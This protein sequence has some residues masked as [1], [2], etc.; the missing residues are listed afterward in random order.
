MQPNS[1]PAAADSAS[2]LH[3]IK[4]ETLLSGLKYHAIRW[5]LKK[6]K[7]F[8]ISGMIHV[9]LKALTPFSL[10]F[11]RNPQHSDQ[12]L[13]ALWNRARAGIVVHYIRSM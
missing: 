2:V 1:H 10:C 12:Q 11:S 13:W 4:A 7:P 9:C 8:I 3:S 5:H 6:L